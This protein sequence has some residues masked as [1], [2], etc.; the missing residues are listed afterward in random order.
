MG[1]PEM[2]SEGNHWVAVVL[3][4]QNRRILFGDSL[5]YQLHATILAMLDWWLRPAFEQP[6]SIYELQYNRQAGSWS[7]RDQAVNMMAH[8]LSLDQ[9]PLLGHTTEVEVRN[10]IELLMGIVGEI[11]TL[12]CIFSLSSAVL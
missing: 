11:R 2:P 8:Y 6:F 10:R 9:F 3:D 12:V 7:C 5:G 1:M 4:G